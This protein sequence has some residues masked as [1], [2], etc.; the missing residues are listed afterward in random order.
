MLMAYKNVLDQRECWRRWYKN[1]KVETR[2]RVS[3][4]RHAL[5]LEIE[6]LK[7]TLICRDCSFPFAEHVECCDFHHVGG[8]HKDGNVAS[9]IATSGSRKKVYDE[10]AKCVPL[11]ANCHRILHNKQKIHRKQLHT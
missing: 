9:L 4:R 2:R 7:R 11:C 6:V 8:A 3:E 1:N 10:I 5:R